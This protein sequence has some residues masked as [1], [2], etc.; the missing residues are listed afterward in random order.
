MGNLDVAFGRQRF[1]CGAVERALSDG[2][3]LHQ[4]ADR[5]LG[6]GGVGGRDRQTGKR[7]RNG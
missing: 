5:L 6:C 7:A 4:F 1:E 2:E 3:A